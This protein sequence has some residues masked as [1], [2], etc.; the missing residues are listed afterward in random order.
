M[1]SG[2]F[3]PIHIGHIRYMQEAKKLGDKLIVVINNDNWLRVKKG[4]EFMPEN[5]RKEIIEALDCVD[6]VFISSHSENTDDMSVCQE[7][8]K[9]KPH[10]F[11]NGG[12]RFAGDIPE[13]KL[14]NDLGIKMV[15]NVGKGGKVRSSSDL[16]NEYL[17]KIS[18]VAKK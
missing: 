16:L 10:I 15:F 1:V 7:I 12:D 18:T 3:D 9:I 5:E 2:G 4:K 8:F 13:F 11:A 17:K 6:E 14:C